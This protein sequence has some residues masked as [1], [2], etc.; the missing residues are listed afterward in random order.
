MTAESSTPQPQQRPPV[1]WS[2]RLVI[3][4]VVVV[5]T[6]L[7]ALILSAFLPR[8]WAHRIGDQVDQSTVNGILLG[9]F[10]GIVFTLLPLLVLWFGFRRRRPWKVWLA[11]VVGAMVVAIPNLLTLSIV[12]GR[13]NAAHAG[14]RILDTEASYFRAWTL[15]GAV[16][17]LV[18]F[19]AIMWLWLRRRGLSKREEQLQKDRAEFDRSRSSHPDKES[20]D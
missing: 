14:E 10:Y 12:V 15:V 3:G 20:D 16:V 18:I 11:F 9:L 2:R 8:W 1:N 7:L 17:A 19:L 13:G 6:L 5:A 4:G